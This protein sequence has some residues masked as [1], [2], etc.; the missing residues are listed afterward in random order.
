M[1]KNKKVEAISISHT[2]GT[3]RVPRSLLC[4]RHWQLLL[5]KHWTPREGGATMHP[6]RRNCHCTNPE[7][8]PPP[9]NTTQSSNP[10]VVS[11]PHA[12]TL[13]TP[14]PQL[15]HMHLHLSHQSFHCC[16]PA[17]LPD[18][19]AAIAEKVFMLLPLALCLLH[20]Y[21]HMSHQYHHCHRCTKRINLSQNI[22]VE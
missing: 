17:S 8:Q 7:P 15:V 20:G 6:L 9:T 18:P 10:T 11:T 19:G 12:P 22:P 5:L 16:G 2:T 1:G 4:K 21:F 13:H 3:I 14:P